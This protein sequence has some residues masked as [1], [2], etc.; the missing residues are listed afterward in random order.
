MAPIRRRLPPLSC[1]AP[2]PR[3]PADLRAGGKVAV[4]LVPERLDI[5]VLSA[6]TYIRG[7]LPLSHAAAARDIEV[8]LASAEEALRL[9]PDLFITQRY[10]V[11]DEAA[12]RALIAHAAETGAPLLYDLDDDLV[13]LPPEHPDAERLRP[14]TA[15]VTM[16]LAGADQVHVST[17]TLAV[18]VA[19][20]VRGGRAGVVVTPNGLDEGLWRLGE[21]EVA[22][23]HGSAL[24]LAGVQAGPVRIL[25]MGTATH[26][27]DLDLILPALARLQESFGERIEIDLVGIVG[28]RDLPP[29]VKRLE[30]PRRAGLS[31]P[32]FVAWLTDRNRREPWAIGLAPLV[33][34]PFNRCKSAIKML[35]YAALGLPV[36]AS[37][38]PAYHGAGDVGLAQPLSLEGVQA[39]G[40]LAADE[41]QW[42]HAMARLVRRPD[43][44]L[45]MA[46]QGRAALRR[47]GTLAAQA[48]WRRAILAALVPEAGSRQQSRTV[49]PRPAKPRPQTP[50]APRPRAKVKS[51]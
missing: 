33:D 1:A 25:Y 30:V 20:F 45:A 19:P 11:G 17:E 16:L 37:D 49:S 32:A 27:A 21:A 23:T 7:L 22:S 8:T 28:P 40:F 42:F 13:G 36:V 5:G 12:A 10:A 48:E 15:G 44:R 39:G 3:A 6:C 34:T 29:F 14:R 9:R 18:R 4:V 24:N 51:A 35:D 47:H 38:M 31:Y 46:A 26:G 41:G 50:V 43:L 2:E